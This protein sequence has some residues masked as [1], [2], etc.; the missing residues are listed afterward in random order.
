MGR[1]NGELFFYYRVLMP[2]D[3]NRPHTHRMGKKYASHE[4]DITV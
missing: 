2:E 3:I 4:E 1:R